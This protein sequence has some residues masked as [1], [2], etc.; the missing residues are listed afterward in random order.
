M[1]VSW[2]RGTVPVII[3]LEISII[4]SI[5]KVFF[6]YPLWLC[7]HQDF[8][9]RSSPGDDGGNLLL[10]THASHASHA[11]LPTPWD[12]RNYLVGT[13]HKAPAMEV[14]WGSHDGSMVLVYMLTWLGYV[15]GIHVTIYSSTMDP[16]WGMVQRFWN[17]VLVTKGS[18]FWRG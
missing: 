10:Q 7:F 11:S 15:D 8:P 5:P 3:P 12:R 6:G 16:S 18:R 13:S 17:S 9:T 2:N 4:F 1:E 14:F